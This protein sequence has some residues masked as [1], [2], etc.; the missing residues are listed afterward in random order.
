MKRDLG[1]VLIFVLINH[2]VNRRHDPAPIWKQATQLDFPLPGV[3]QMSDN[4]GNVTKEELRIFVGRNADYYCEKWRSIG[5]GETGKAALNA[6]AAL[7]SPLWM[8]Y[9]KF[10]VLLIA[11]LIFVLA[12]GLLEELIF[13]VWLGKPDAVLALDVILMFVNAI[14]IGRY[15]N[16]WYYRYACWKIRNL[17]AIETDPQKQIQLIVRKG[18]TSLLTLGVPV[19]L[20]AAFATISRY[21]GW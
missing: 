14:I 9:R 7:F 5:F 2:C 13:I 15:A 21:A 6:G 4:A 1:G 8:L 12:E 16:Y 19:I 11:F 20:I 3:E 10:Y 18:G 17:K